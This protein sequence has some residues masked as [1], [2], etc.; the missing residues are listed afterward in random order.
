MHTTAVFATS[1]QWGKRNYTCWKKE[2]PLTHLLKPFAALRSTTASENA[3]GKLHGSLWI[4]LGKHDIHREVC[5]FSFS[6]N[7][8]SCIWNH[9]FH[10][11]R[12]GGLPYNCNGTSG[13][14]DKVPHMSCSWTKLPCLLI[15]GESQ[16]SCW[17]L[18]LNSSYISFESKEMIQ[19][20]SKTMGSC[21]GPASF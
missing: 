9:F 15:W 20:Q 21:P 12:C 6:E 16:S 1:V 4:H 8:S 14:Q 13:L 18:T 10:S 17:G 7:I 2:K 19:S 3:R 11:P 5:D